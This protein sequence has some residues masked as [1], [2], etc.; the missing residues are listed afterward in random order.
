[1]PELRASSRAA[2]PGETLQA[3]HLAGLRVSLGAAAGAEGVDPED[4]RRGT[5]ASSEALQY[6]L[7]LAWLASAEE[8]FQVDHSGTESRHDDWD[9]SVQD[10]VMVTSRSN[11]YLEAGAGSD[12]G[13]GYSH[14]STSDPDA[15][16]IF[17]T[18]ISNMRARPLKSMVTGSTQGQKGRIRITVTLGFHSDSA[19]S[20]FARQLQLSCHASTSS[21]QDG[22]LSPRSD[23]LKSTRSVFKEIL[24]RL[25]AHSRDSILEPIQNA[26]QPVIQLL[27][28]AV[29]D[30]SLRPYPE[31]GR[32]RKVQSLREAGAH[33]RNIIS[34]VAG[35]R[36][37]GIRDTEV[38]GG[39][40]PTQRDSQ[41]TLPWAGLHDGG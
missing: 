17:D 18:T 25:A 15:G 19:R 27:A 28:D 31:E 5:A 35:V 38:A 40:G 7:R 32:A 6:R 39:A 23:K 33:L 8:A 29:D 34:R 37:V 4:S 41:V 14:R 13:T 36:W 22:R 16:G 11:A 10:A 21:Y 20:S 30:T 26:A 9:Q 2:T 24:D 3:L 1:M 12:D